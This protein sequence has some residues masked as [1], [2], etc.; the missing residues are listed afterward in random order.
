MKKSFLLLSIFTLSAMVLFQSC[1]KDD[2]NQDEPKSIE[3]YIADDASFA[4]FMSWSL[5]ATTHGA[6]PSLGPAHAGNDSTVTRNIYFKNGQ[7]IENGAYP[8]GT[9]I[10]KHSSNPAGNVNEFTAMVKRGNSFNTAGGNWEWFMLQP[11]GKIAIDEA[12][13]MAMRG[14]DLM[15][16]MCVSCHNVAADKDYVFTK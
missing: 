11:D 3:E 13:G 2:D 7:D 14:A 5:D 15:N 4:D 16:G 9:I 10:V 6:D 12:S 8:T 1:K